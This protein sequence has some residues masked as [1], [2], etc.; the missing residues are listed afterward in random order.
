MWRRLSKMSD[1]ARYL[2]VEDNVDSRD[3][4]AKL[5]GMK[6]YEVSSASDGES[7]YA[8]ALSQLPDPIITDINMPIMDGIALL[9][10]VR[11]DRLLTGTAVWSSPLWGRGRTRGD[12]CGGRMRQRRSLST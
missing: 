8:A 2:V 10:K 7:G 12:R 1:R 4:L 3:L 9:K 6:G 11:L 5:L